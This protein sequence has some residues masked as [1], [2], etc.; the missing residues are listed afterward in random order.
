MDNLEDSD[1]LSLTNSSPFIRTLLSKE[2]I[3]S[4][5]KLVFEIAVLNLAGDSEVQIKTEAKSFLLQSRLVCKEW[6]TVVD[7]VVSNWFVNNR[8]HLSQP[9]K[10][11]SDWL[12][13]IYTFKGRSERFNKFAESFKKTYS[14]PIDNP[15]V[16]R[17]IKILTGFIGDAHEFEWD[18]ARM[19]CLL[20]TY[21]FHIWSCEINIFNTHALESGTYQRIVDCLYKLPKLK[22]LKI[23]YEGD[24]SRK[25]WIGDDIHPNTK[26]LM[27]LRMENLRTLELRSVCSFFSRKIFNRSPNLAYL[28]VDRKFLRDPKCFPYLKLRP[29]LETLKICVYI[30]NDLKDVIYSY[31]PLKILNLK[32][33]SS[34]ISDWSKFLENISKFLWRLRVLQ[35]HNLNYETHY[36]SILPYPLNGRLD[37]FYLKTFYLEIYSIVSLDFLLLTRCSL[38]EISIKICSVNLYG[39]TNEQFLAMEKDQIIQFLGYEGKLLESNIWRLLPKLKKVSVELYS[40]KLDYKREQ[41]MKKMKNLGS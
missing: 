5:Y 29:V 37:L 10:R 30:P 1:F 26:H 32:C 14:S 16:G 38:E 20:D 7:T 24:K 22:N 25:N 39:K 11:L 8:E 27:R 33:C 2:R 13:E 4:L 28:T 31:Y 19:S 23:N 15:F 36:N 21:G 9:A 18:H 17:Y 6:K 3:Y 34:L 35:L 12:C 40:F 41:W